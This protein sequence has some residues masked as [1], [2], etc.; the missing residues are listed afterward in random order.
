MRTLDAALRDFRLATR[1]LF[2][3][4]FRVESDPYNNGGWELLERFCEVE[5]VLFEQLVARN[6]KSD[7]NRYSMHQ[8]TILVT[9]EG[10]GAAPAMINRDVD[11]GYWDHPVRELSRD[12]TLQF[13]RFFDW[14]Q[15]A[16][17]DNGY[18][19]VV[20][21]KCPDHPEVEGKHA[22]IESKWAH[23]IEA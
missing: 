7:L 4:Y 14:D 11:S 19:R 5:D 13:V 10:S 18:V 8:P 6:C 12:A 21:V 1:E 2:N 17:R 3:N 22:L 16:I 15:L 9:I 23:F 20:I